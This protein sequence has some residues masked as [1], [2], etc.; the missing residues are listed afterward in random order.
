MLRVC[1]TPDSTACSK[2]LQKVCYICHTTDILRN[3]VIVMLYRF[4]SICVDNN[5]T[6][7]CVDIE[8]YGFE[9]FC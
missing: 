4:T 3:N 2:L 6:S 9:F 8:L 7:V 5:I 1:G